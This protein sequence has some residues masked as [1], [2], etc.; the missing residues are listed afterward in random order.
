MDETYFKSLAEHIP[1]MVWHCINGSCNYVNKTWT[2][3]TGLSP[4]ESL[5]NGY[6]KAFHPDDVERE[7]EL[8][9]KAVDNHAVYESKYRL[10][11]KDGAYRW[12]ITKAFPRLFDGNTIEYIG[13]LIDITEQEV[14]RQKIE[15][16][17]QQVRQMADSI[18]QM[19]WVTDAN[20]M[21]EY[22]N[23]R[24]Y[25]FTGV[26]HEQS[27]GEGWSD[28]FHPDDREKAWKKWNHSL[29]TGDIYEIEYRLKKHT[30][31]YVWVLG[32]AAPFIDS[33]GKILKWFGTCTDIN[34]QILIQ[35]HKDEFI[36]IASHE[37]KTPLTSLTTSLQL[38]GRQLSKE[39]DIKPEITKM[40]ELASLQAK[41]L[42]SLVNDLLN[43]T[44]LEHGQIILHKTNFIIS[45]LAKDCFNAIVTAKYS[46][47][48]TGDLALSVF[49]DACKV[50]QV[51][52]N[53][54]NNAI[55][56][57][58]DSKNILIVIEEV[59]SCAKVSII[60]KGAGI[61]ESKIPFLF[62]RYYRADHSGI[63]SSGLGLGLYICAEIIKQH[64]GQIGVE[65]EPDEG[66]TF[67][68]T[69]PL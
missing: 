51:I 25:D 36:S 6:Q 1:F 42:T 57:A 9:K 47:T 12:V 2:D 15:E 37:L 24:W 50:E 14:A 28:M 5:G 67:W 60:D 33:H 22:F 52:A 40:Y 46:L 18:I 59:N 64:F 20:G 35:Q 27:K 65:S 26:N 55:K 61:S 16:S 45:Q 38:L 34:E 30:G 17:E 23:K 58:P 49:A 62:D 13:S 66:S 53:F 3:F 56:Y 43:I 63:K 69:L 7:W 19:I 39:N 41:K 31:E 10:L 11:R 32:R 44:N 54:I 68:F 21:H 48:V 4:E 29:K 8:Y